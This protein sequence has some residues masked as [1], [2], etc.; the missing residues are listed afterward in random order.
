[1]TG[2]DKEFLYINDPLANEKNMSVN[3]KNYEEAW[4]Q[5]GRQAFV[6]S[7]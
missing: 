3:H 4:I 7:G 1:M 2:Y 5:M 6:I